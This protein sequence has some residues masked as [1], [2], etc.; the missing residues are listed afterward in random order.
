MW[1]TSLSIKAQ[2]TS[3]FSIK[4]I[5]IKIVL[6]TWN[7]KQTSHTSSAKCYK[8]IDPEIPRIPWFLN[9]NLSRF[10]TISFSKLRFGYNRLPLTLFI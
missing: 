3:Y 5:T 8:S 10:H 4:F 7:T 9:Y 1:I 6:S 2:I